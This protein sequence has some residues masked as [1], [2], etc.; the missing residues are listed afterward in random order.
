MKKGGVGGVGMLLAGY[1]VLSYIWSYPHISEC[2][3]RF[4]VLPYNGL[5][6]SYLKRLKR[7]IFS[8]RAQSLEEVSLRSKEAVSNNVTVR[9]VTVKRKHLLTLNL[10]KNPHH[11]FSLDL[12]LLKLLFY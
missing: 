3:H 9:N 12:Y 1:C 10:I 6:L 5:I 7:H 11:E 2:D 8:F 4:S